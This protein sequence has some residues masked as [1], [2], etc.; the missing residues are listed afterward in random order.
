M[1]FWILVLANVA[2]VCAIFGNVDVRTL[3]P[4]SVVNDEQ[5]AAEQALIDELKTQVKSLGEQVASVEESTAVGRLQVPANQ[6]E[7]GCD[8]AWNYGATS[9]VYL[10]W[11]DEKSGVTASLP[12][13]FDWGNERYSFLPYEVWT[14]DAETSV[15][16]G[17]GSPGGAC[18]VGRDAYL[19]I[20]AVDTTSPDKLL[21]EI[22]S[23]EPASE[24]IRQRTIGGVTVISATRG[25]LGRG[26][27]WYIFGR[28]YFY[29]LSSQDW[30]TDAE[31]IKIIQSLRVTK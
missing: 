2:L 13:S 4:V 5:Q 30:L 23:D 9:T 28:S 7:D 26:P 6:M 27:V 24:N 8:L 29:T 22:R 31:A 3:K 18:G 16:F 17:P 21:S 15:H 11:K 10:S 1:I 12:Y 19:M 14:F 20:E 25:E